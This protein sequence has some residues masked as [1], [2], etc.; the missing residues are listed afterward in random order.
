M[1]NSDMP[2][3]PAKMLMGANTTP[4]TV[5][6]HADKAKT[7]QTLQ[8]IA[9]IFG[10]E[11]VAEGIETDDD[12][13]LLRDLGLT[14]G[15][16]YF[17]A[18][19]HAQPCTA[20]QPGAVAVLVNSQVAVYPEVRQSTQA[21]IFDRLNILQAP[22]MGPQTQIDQVAALF[23][24]HPH[25]HA[26]PLVGGD[27]PIGIINRMNFL[28]RYSKLYS[29]EMWGN[30]PCL[31]ESKHTIDDLLG[32]LTSDD[33][34]YLDDGFIVVFQ[35][36]NWAA[37]CRCMI[38]EFNTQAAHLFDE[39]DRQRGGIEAQ[40]RQGFSQFFALTT[41]SIGAVE[42]HP[43]DFGNAEQVANAAA[44]AKQSADGMALWGQE[45]GQTT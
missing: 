1:E 43:G 24:K 23:L 39:R 13:R 15:Q 27:S 10:S 42:V 33:Q 29:R 6:T 25:L 17:L 26:L 12:L 16:G 4:N 36:A 5:S 30:K 32:I 41:L 14:F 28:D 3:M 21:N 2:P 9:E 34:R 19:P 31:I 35:R 22:T 11:L 20:V 8:K 45:A 37:Q 38:E 7:I 44:A 18:R 40:D